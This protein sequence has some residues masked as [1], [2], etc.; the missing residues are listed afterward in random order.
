[1]LFYYNVFFVVL[2]TAWASLGAL[3]V[4]VLDGLQLCM[5]KFCSLKS[6]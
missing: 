6:R 2:S 3:T 1:M 5:E 4:P